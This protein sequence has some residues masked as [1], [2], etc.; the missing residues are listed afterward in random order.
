MNMK[1]NLATF[2]VKGHRFV[3]KGQELI[4]TASAQAEGARRVRIRF[5]SREYFTLLARHP[6]SLLTLARNV[7]LTL[8]DTIYEIYE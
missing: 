3:Q 8:D 2:F 6:T 7:C 5:D 1:D 4:D